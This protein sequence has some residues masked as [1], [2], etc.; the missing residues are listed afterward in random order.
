MKRRTG[1]QM[2][3]LILAFGG[4]ASPVVHAGVTFPIALNGGTLYLNGVGTGTTIT[5]AG[6]N[7]LQTSGQPYA[8]FN[9]QGSG[10]LNVSLGSDGIF[11]PGGDWSGFSGTIHFTTGNW[12][13]E[14]NT[15]AFGSSNTVWDFGN[16][17]AGLYNKNG[18][19]TISLG[20]LFGGGGT[21]ISGASTAA[22][23]LTTYVIG[24]INTNS[25]FN[26]TISD[27]GA[28]ATALVFNGPGTLTLTG[29][30]PYT[31]GTAVNAGTLFVNNTA[32]SGTG[33]GI[34]SVNSGATLAG[35]GAIG[36]VVTIA[37]AGILAP[38]GSAPGTL[39]ISND[40]SLDNVSVLQFQLG[41][42]SDRI[43]LTGDLTLGGALN[44][45]NAG[46]FKTGTYTLFNYGGALSVGSLSIASAPAGYTYAIDT[47][48]QGQVNLIVSLPQFGSLRAI[49]NGLIM[50][51]SGGVSNAAYYLLTTT[52][53]ARPLIN[54]TRLLTNQFDGNGNFTLTNA[55][56]ANSP[57]T[58]YRL[59]LQ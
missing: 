6:T 54:W 47:S 27:G 23:S 22:A 1:I 12:M 15:T 48:T 13:R 19:A 16:S 41:A 24:G 44:I 40:L 33:S 57:Q 53:I 51:G 25:V 45:S 46:G 36:G 2:L 49:P 8:S 32:G 28:A 17:T 10:C 42:N 26:G 55:I 56:S 4:L 14:L 20:A 59:Q 3:F 37:A 30:N 7:T 34:V 38:G 35:A 11:S 43:S 29:N 52:N 31:G 58:F 9:L 39:T 21:T 50:S 18:G 5:C